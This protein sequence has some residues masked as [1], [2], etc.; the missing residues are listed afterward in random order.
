MQA[1]GVIVATPTGSTAY[2]TS[3]GGSMVSESKHACSLVGLQNIC[4]HQ[5]M[6]MTCSYVCTGQQQPCMQLH[7][8]QVCF[9][10]CV[11]SSIYVEI[12]FNDMW[13]HFQVHPNVPCMLF[14]PIC[15]HSLSF[16]PV[17][18]PDSALLELK[19]C[20]LIQIFLSIVK[21]FADA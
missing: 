11:C 13:W 20:L 9:H 21:Y 4:T 14:T 12:G 19:V 3:A 17:I 2:S 18:L 15:P 6:C 5:C 10:K 1:D 16:R 8:K 7:T